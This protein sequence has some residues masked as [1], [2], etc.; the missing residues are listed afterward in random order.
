MSDLPMRGGV[1]YHLGIS[2]EQLAPAILIVG[3]PE[4]VDMIADQFFEEREFRVSHRGLTTCTGTVRETKQR[5]TVTTTGMGAPSTEIVLNEISALAEVDASTRTR[6]SSRAA[7]LTI[8]RVGTSGALQ[9]AT[10]LGTAILSSHAVGLDST[11]WFYAEGL[12]EDLTARELAGTVQD[13]IER[14]LVPQHAALGKI[15]PYGAIADVA[16]VAALSQSARELGVSHQVGATITASGFFAP[17]GRHISR[18][19]PSVPDI[20]RLLAREPSFLNMDMETAFVLH[21]CGAFGYRAGAVC[22]AAAHRELDTF[23][24]DIASHVSDAVRVALLALARVPG[25]AD[26]RHIP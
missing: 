7:N 24:T 26:C 22:V 1:A 8:I 19:T 6:R 14:A 15:H 4:R 5:V 21:L 18:V 10:S 25:Q 23:S 16:V 17:Q 3:D 20:D 11:A 12:T 2:A 13:V 9:P